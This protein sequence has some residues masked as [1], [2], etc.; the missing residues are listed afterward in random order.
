[1]NVIPPHGNKKT[2]EG[3]V[4]IKAIKSMTFTKEL[5][6]KLERLLKLTEN[7]SI[8]F[9]YPSIKEKPE[10]QTLKSIFYFLSTKQV[11]SEDN[12][13]LKLANVYKETLTV[14]DIL[15]QANTKIKNLEEL[16][17]S[18]DDYKEF[19]VMHMPS[20][21]FWYFLSADHFCQNKNVNQRLKR[22]EEFN[23]LISMITEQINYIYSRNKAKHISSYSPTQSANFLIGFWD[24]GYVQNVKT[25]V[26]ELLKKPK[27][28]N[29]RDLI[30]PIPKIMQS[31]LDAVTIKYPDEPRDCYSM[32]SFDEIMKLRDQICQFCFFAGHIDIVCR[33]D[34]SIGLSVI[35][36]HVD[37]IIYAIASMPRHLCNPIDAYA[38][39]KDVMKFIEKYE[40][41]G[42]FGEVIKAIS[43]TFQ[44]GFMIEAQCKSAYITLGQCIPSFESKVIMK[45]IKDDPQGAYFFSVAVSRLFHA[46]KSIPF[47]GGVFQ[48]TDKELNL[49]ENQQVLQS[50][51]RDV[52]SLNGR[53]SIKMKPCEFQQYKINPSRTA[54]S[55]V[56]VS[57]S[58]AAKN[59]TSELHELSDSL[60]EMNS[61]F[62]SLGKPSLEEM[63]DAIRKAY[64]TITT[65]YAIGD[66]GKEEGYFYKCIDE[67]NKLVDNI[68]AEISSKVAS[69]TPTQ[70]IIQILDNIHLMKNDL[71]SA[72]SGRLKEKVK[73]VLSKLKEIESRYSKYKTGI[74]DSQIVE[75]SED[76]NEDVKFIKELGIG[77][78]IDKEIRESYFEEHRNSVLEDLSIIISRTQVMNH[79]KFEMKDVSEALIAAA[80]EIETIYEA[81]TVFNPS[82]SIFARFLE[83]NRHIIN[84]IHEQLLG[85]QDQTQ[86]SQYVDTIT[87]LRT[88]LEGVIPIM[89]MIND[90]QGFL[91]VLSKL[92]EARWYATHLSSSYT[93]DKNICKAI[94]VCVDNAEVVLSKYKNAQFQPGISLYKEIKKKLNRIGRKFSSETER[95]GNEDEASVAEL[96]EMLAKIH[97]MMCQPD[98]CDTRYAA[99]DLRKSINKAITA[100]GFEAVELKPAK[101]PY[102]S[103]KG[104]AFDSYALMLSETCGISDELSS[105]MSR[106]IGAIDKVGK[107]QIQLITSNYLSLLSPNSSNNTEA[108][109][110]NVRSIAEPIVV[111]FCISNMKELKDQLFEA[112]K[113]IVSSQDTVR[114]GLLEFYSCLLTMLEYETSADTLAEFLETGDEDNAPDAYFHCKQLCREMPELNDIL[115][116][117]VASSNGEDDIKAHDFTEIKKKLRFMAIDTIHTEICPLI[118]ESTIPV[119]VSKEFEDYNQH[120][121]DTAGDLQ[122]EVNADEEED[123]EFDV[124]IDSLNELSDQVTQF[125][126]LSSR[127]LLLIPIV[128]LLPKLRKAF[129]RAHSEEELAI[130][131]SI[132]D[133]WSVIVNN[134]KIGTARNGTL[135]QSYV[136]DAFAFRLNKMLNLSEKHAK[137][138]GFWGDY[139]C[140]ILKKLSSAAGDSVLISTQKDFI[141]S[142]RNGITAFC[143]NMA[144]VGYQEESGKLLD[145]YE[146]LVTVC[147]YIKCDGNI[148]ES[149][150]EVKAGLLETENIVARNF[151]R[152]KDTIHSYIELFIGEIGKVHDVSSQE[153]DAILAS[154]GTSLCNLPLLLDFTN[155]GDIVHK[156]IASINNCRM[157]L[158]RKGAFEP[159]VFEELI[160]KAVKAMKSESVEPSIIIEVESMGICSK[161]LGKSTMRRKETSAFLKDQASKLSAYKESCE[162]I[163]AAF[164]YIDDN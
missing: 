160:N 82:N 153:A 119:C 41:E 113:L 110:N 63:S 36:Y 43:D 32:I 29:Y 61:K 75:M 69:P 93:N 97:T 109:I 148:D 4:L 11:P 133:D 77:T 56:P 164:K 10:I 139:F 132:T 163:S 99:D 152:M 106:V 76:L 55:I 39:A 45:E 50:V 90:G 49:E 125:V 151:P 147:G 12:K 20:F 115:S 150:G 87:R 15:E 120:F 65:S 14:E 47:N 88:D 66:Y 140:F 128:S 108:K 131:D 104:T 18:Y 59:A 135:T 80:S 13:F 94:S 154:I 156:T 52:G 67:L 158:M 127:D 5:R 83:K 85:M 146:T 22:K 79:G 48:A 129:K 101:N 40:I 81:V 141:A 53:K 111:G 62:Q 86:L 122:T 105:T 102:D 74:D 33:S 1:M 6:P 107:D 142:I 123:I 96:S 103:F 72:S 8:E 95:V 28:I 155:E 64:K 60:E 3:V 89:R 92:S 34:I 162:L 136:L 25:V 126:E 44:S 24:D 117:I 37:N 91:K 38:A 16:K 116:I 2:I 9:P 124:N 70:L 17:N 30:E 144:A 149:I 26:F 68:R 121:I 35:L 98:N 54:H 143:Q 46:M 134:A 27:L 157:L 159:P 114:R 130:V 31:L 137:E 23:K 73:P 118:M 112:I 161:I 42:N 58:V 78:M 7:N 71:R 57:E 19:L 100:F 145:A 21:T 51:N 84:I 138:I